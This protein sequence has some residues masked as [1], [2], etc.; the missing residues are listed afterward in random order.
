MY[1][2]SKQLLRVSHCYWHLFQGL[3]FV[4]FC[5]NKIVQYLIETTAFTSWLNEKSQ[6]SY[7]NVMKSLWKSILWFALN[8]RPWCILKAA[9]TAL[10]TNPSCSRYKSNL[11]TMRVGKNEKVTMLIKDICYQLTFA[12][13]ARPCY[14]FCIFVSIL[15]RAMWCLG[16]LNWWLQPF[17]QGGEAYDDLCGLK[18]VHN[19]KTS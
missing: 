3:N 6:I 10:A 8:F 12:H 16:W 11:T 9:D 1:R 13:A 4:S 7:L 2:I 5:K 15:G 17:G 14:R 18:I 19:C